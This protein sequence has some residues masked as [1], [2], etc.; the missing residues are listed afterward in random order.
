MSLKEEKLYLEFLKD[1]VTF[2]LGSK[3]TASS[4]KQTLKRIGI[5]NAELDKVN[6]SMKHVK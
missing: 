4:F 1:K 6:Q 5:I 2:S 3:I